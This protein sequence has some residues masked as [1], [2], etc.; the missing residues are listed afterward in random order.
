MLKITCVFKTL[1]HWSIGTNEEAHSI[2]LSAPFSWRNARPLADN[3]RMHLPFSVLTT[4]VG[5]L[6]FLT[7]Y[8]VLL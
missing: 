1:I 3:A 5:R 4:V 7:I 8:T 2:I 6:S